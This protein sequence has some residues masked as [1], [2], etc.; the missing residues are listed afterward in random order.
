MFS[1]EGVR[2]NVLALTAA[3]ALAAATPALAQNAPADPNA[4]NLTLT[5]GIDAL[6]T[7]MFRGIRQDDTGVIT[8]PFADLG[9]SLYS[10]DTTLKS[11]TVNV[12]SWNSLHTGAAGLDS[13]D[14]QLG[15]ATGKLWYESD[16]YATVGVGLAGGVS[17]GT[18]YTA[19]TSPNSMFG[20][21][22]EVAFKLSLDDSAALGR[23]AVKPYA[24]VAFELEGQADAGTNEGTYLELGVAPGWAANAISLA[25][26]V[27]IGLS[28]KDYYEL[29]GVDQKF[30]YVSVGGIVTVPIAGIPASFGSWNVHG[31]VE[32][33][34]LG[35]AT[36]AINLGDD[37]KVIGS[38]GIGLSY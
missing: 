17:V 37:S 20:T 1:T 25:F 30:G 29:D 38:F 18:T 9:L 14:L 22:K 19:Y 28:L 21:V 7:Y 26:P 27:K 13:D 36:R 11:V 3:A 23:G 16:F 34:A 24:L 5:A 33:Q 6:N 35:D 32:Y 15:S 4:G 8:W 31:G 10:G 2:R 12:G